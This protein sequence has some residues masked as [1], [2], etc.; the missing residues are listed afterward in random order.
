MTTK[1]VI[2]VIVA[3]LVG[4]TVG[5]MVGSSSFSQE[6]LPIIVGSQS[7]V[8]TTQ[9]TARVASITVSPSTVAATSTSLY[10]SGS[11]RLI[12]DSFVACTGVGTSMTYLT[13]TGLAS[14]TLQ[15]STSSSVI[16]A[17]TNTNY[18]SNITIGTSSPWSYVSSSTEGV[19]TSSRFWPSGTY[20][21]ITFNATNT[22]ACT[23]GASYLSL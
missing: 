21:N 14:W 18:A 22:A 6:P 17:K 2:G 11:D 15:M 8:G 1:N 12:R 4:F 7:A 5:N 10:N 9:N 20:L 19:L 23:V 13:G 16:D 3:L